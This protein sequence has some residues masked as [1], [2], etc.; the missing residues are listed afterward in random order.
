MMMP[1]TGSDSIMLRLR[2]ETKERHE[3]A[4]HGRLPRD[5]MKGQLDRALYLDLL[6]QLRLVHRALEDALLHGLR[7][8]LRLANVVRSE[9]F[10]AAL[11]EADLAHFGVSANDYAEATALPATEALIESIRT[12]AAAEPIALLG[13]HYVLEGAKNG[14]RF[15]AKAVRRAYGLD[16]RDGVASLDPHGDE[17][18]ALWAGFKQAMD[19]LDLSPLERDAIVQNA[20]VTFDQI[21]ALHDELYDGA[22]VG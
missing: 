4:E 11:V 15:V 1:S 3:R 8:D 17:Q 21:A 9:Q 19:Q 10:Q 5:L 18:P 13:F 16:G 20:K 7:C 2:E 14:N 12:A 6:I 22:H